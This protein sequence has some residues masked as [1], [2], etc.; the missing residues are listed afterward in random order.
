M[1]GSLHHLGTVA[2]IFSAFYF[3]KMVGCD[4]L[5]A[6]AKYIFVRA[7]V[8]TAGF[9]TLRSARVGDVA[10]GGGAWSGRLRFS[11]EEV[12]V[13]LEHSLVPGRLKLSWPRR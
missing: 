3:Y 8:G 13:S 7:A 6:A 10:F 1:C 9:A 2:G 5:K 4:A 11:E 12:D